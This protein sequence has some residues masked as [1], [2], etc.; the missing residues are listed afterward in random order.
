MPCEPDPDTRL[1]VSEPDLAQSAM[2]PTFASNATHAGC[3]VVPNPASDPTNRADTAADDDVLALFPDE[4]E[5][6]TLLPE[7]LAGL[8]PPPRPP[9]SRDLTPENHIVLKQLVS[10]TSG[11][12]KRL[13]ELDDS[14]VKLLGEYQILDRELRDAAAKLEGE[15]R[16]TTE[17]S[18]ASIAGSKASRMKPPPS[19]P[20][21]I[22]RSRNRHVKPSGEVS[23]RRQPSNKFKR[24]S[25]SCTCFRIW[26]RRKS[27]SPSSM[28]ARINWTKGWHARQKNAPSRST[29]SSR[30]CWP[31]SRLWPRRWYV[32]RTSRNGR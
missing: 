26:P 6:S 2:D 15:L 13:D 30:S 25:S 19:S 11:V 9:A 14:A 10:R 23:R 20:R 8:E 24:A 29:R 28:H 18:P 31:A 22:P 21:N 17:R 32:S 3:E 12:K 1:T 4:P 7:S 16:D 27:G 5:G